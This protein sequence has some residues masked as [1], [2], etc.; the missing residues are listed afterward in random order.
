MSMAQAKMEIYAVNKCMYEDLNVVANYL[1]KTKALIYI[2][3]FLL[4]KKS[5]RYYNNPFDLKKVKHSYDHRET[6]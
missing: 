1:K 4:L 3:L 5:S 2:I 6:I